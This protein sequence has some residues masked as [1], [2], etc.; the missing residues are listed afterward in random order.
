MY[1]KHV[2]FKNVVTSYKISNI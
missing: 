1:E 2:E